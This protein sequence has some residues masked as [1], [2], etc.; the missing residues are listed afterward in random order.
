MYPWTYLETQQNTLGSTWFCWCIHLHFL[1]FSPAFLLVFVLVSFVPC[2][3]LSSFL[4]SDL[5]LW[6]CHFTL[7]SIWVLWK[8]CYHHNRQQKL[9]W[10]CIHYGDESTVAAEANLLTQSSAFYNI[11]FCSTEHTQWVACRV[12]GQGHTACGMWD[13]LC[14]GR[15]GRGDTAGMM[16]AKA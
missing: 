13:S 5:L 7:I 10:P 15:C 6:Y 3:F 9:F 16:N 12:Q 1:I 2:P 4:I 14:V 11:R 8:Q